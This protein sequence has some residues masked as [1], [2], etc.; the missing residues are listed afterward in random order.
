MATGKDI[1]L[2][3]CK[4]KTAGYSGVN[5]K[6]FST[7]WEDGLGFCALIHSNHPDLLDFNSLEKTNVDKNLKL[8]MTTA[9]KLG[10]PNILEDQDLSKPLDKTIIMTFISSLYHTTLEKGAV[11][12]A[13]KKESDL[14]KEKLLKAQSELNS[15]KERL[16][17]SKKSMAQKESLKRELEK[18]VENLN[19]LLRSEIRNGE[20]LEKRNQQ[21]LERLT[22]QIETSSGT[23]KQRLVQELKEQRRAKDDLLEKQAGLEKEV[24]EIKQQLLEE[25]KMAQRLEE[26]TKR[27]EEEKK[28]LDQ[29]H[30]NKMRELRK[31]TFRFCFRTGSDYKKN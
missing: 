22:A 12:S 24:R 17:A 5:I 27:K 28:K 8:A 21:K 31:K 10:I 2:S 19:Y 13:L 7:S 26:E 1:L 6:D 20:E 15:L 11:N 18:K 23:E 29:I 14:A 4:Q 16:D 3:W 30:K 25:E 9:E